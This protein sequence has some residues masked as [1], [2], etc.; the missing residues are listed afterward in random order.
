[1]SS[2]ASFLPGPLQAVYFATKAYVTSF[3]Q[4]VAEEVRPELAVTGY[5]AK[6]PIETG[7]FRYG[8]KALIVTRIPHAALTA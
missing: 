6:I 3:T 4:A 5:A 8:K 1:V 2:T 7:P